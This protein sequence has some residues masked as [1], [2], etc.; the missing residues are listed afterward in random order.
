MNPT[1]QQPKKS[2]VTRY[3]LDL[4]LVDLIARTLKDALPSMPSDLAVRFAERL[5]IALYREGYLKQD[6]FL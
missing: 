4:D 3:T 5:V 6:T 1:N 2:S